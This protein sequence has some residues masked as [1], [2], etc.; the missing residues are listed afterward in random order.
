MHCEY[1]ESEACRSCTALE[2][3]YDVQLADKDAHARSILADYPEIE[4]LTPATSAPAGFRNK[5]KMAVGNTAEQPTLGLL[6]KNFVGVDT[7]N[8]PLYDSRLREIFPVLREF[9]G[10]AK[11]TPFDVPSGR[12]ELKHLIVTVSPDGLFMVRFVLRSTEAEVRI[13]K[14]LPWLLERIGSYS[15]VTINILPGRVARVEGEQEIILTERDYVD[16]DFGRFSLRLRPRSFFQTNTAVAR[17][18]YEQARVWV[19]EICAAEDVEHGGG[20]DGDAG[21][22]A[23]NVPVRV[24]DLFCGAGGFALSVAGEGREVFGV[25][26][27]EDAVLSASESARQAGIDAQFVVADLQRG[28]YDFP[29]PD[30]AIVNPPRRGIADLTSWLEGCGARWLIYSSCNPDSLARDLAALESYTPVKA[31]IF[32][33]FPHSS[34]VETLVLL[35]RA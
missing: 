1:W 10:L 34:H 27:S 25:E 23:A 13:R 6:D 8:C 2:I 7:S 32:D 20:A 26:I 16:M 35:K 29:A 28:T 17:E 3:P 31:R 24:W 14:H 33:M 30:V 18:L 21:V 4:W 11:L 15:V 9:I 12:R 19:D 22:D 5:A